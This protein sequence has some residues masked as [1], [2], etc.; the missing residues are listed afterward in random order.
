MAAISIAYQDAGLK[1]HRANF[2]ELYVT[3]TVVGDSIE[4]NA[5][6]AML[7][8]GCQGRELVIRSVRSNVG[9]S[10]MGAYMISLI[11]V[12]MMLNRKQILP[13]GK[14]KKHWCKIEFSKYNLRVAR[15][16]EP[17]SPQNPRRQ[18]SL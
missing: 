8:E 7:S 10:E 15:A 17:M 1:P 5:A 12:V 16:V 4:A 3:G 11:K 14:F 6:G 13:N 18:S 2:V 9:H